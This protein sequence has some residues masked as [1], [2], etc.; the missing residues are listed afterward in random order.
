MYT[1]GQCWQRCSNPWRG[2]ACPLNPC[3]DTAKRLIVA[4]FGGGGSLMAT[5]NDHFNGIRL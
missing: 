3:G 1:C 4:R 2:E 5:E